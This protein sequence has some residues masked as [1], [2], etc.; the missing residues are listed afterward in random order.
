MEFKLLIMTRKFNNSQPIYIIYS[1][2][3]TPITFADGTIMM[4]QTFVQQC[5]Q[6]A[7]QYFRFF[8]VGYGTMPTNASIVDVKLAIQD[9]HLKDLVSVEAFIQGEANNGFPEWADAF[10][11][12]G[13]GENQPNDLKELQ[14]LPLN[15]DWPTY[16][17]SKSQIKSIYK[18]CGYIPLVVS[19]LP[20]QEVLSSLLMK[21]KELSKNSYHYLPFIL[22]LH[23][24]I[25]DDDIPPYKVI[26][27]VQ[28]VPRL[29]NELFNVIFYLLDS[30]YAPEAS[31]W[32][33]PMSCLL[34]S[35]LDPNAPLLCSDYF[36][37]I[38]KKESE[39]REK[40]LDPW[41]KFMNDDG[42]TN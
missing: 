36:I 5:F 28:V 16:N 24:D 11:L 6:E 42:E 33:D 13:G 7:N 25:N 35:W 20:R 18:R 8:S 22:G 40:L 30:Y 9:V 23:A 34:S 37:W 21:P 39:W 19:I 27:L 41:D 17:N 29:F 31:P 14:N 32:D 3:D 26:D 10:P 12:R 38:A 1:L 15:L 2:E 4:Y